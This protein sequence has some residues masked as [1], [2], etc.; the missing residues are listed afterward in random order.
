MEHAFREPKLTDNTRSDPP[1]DPQEMRMDRLEQAPEAMKNQISRW[2]FLS[3]S[4]NPSPNPPSTPAITVRNRPYVEV[5]SVDSYRLRDRTAGLR[6]DQVASLNLIANQI[7]PR[8]D[9]YFFRGEP[10]L[11]VLSLL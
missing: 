10:A 3:P 5:L 6:P 11:S 1:N 8:L 4:P 7:R 9:G 2:Q